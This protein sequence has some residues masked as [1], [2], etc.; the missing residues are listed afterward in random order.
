LLVTDL[1]IGK[2]FFDLEKGWRSR[3][4]G[5]TGIRHIAAPVDKPVRIINK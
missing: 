1:Q 4:H 2:S 3:A 5:I